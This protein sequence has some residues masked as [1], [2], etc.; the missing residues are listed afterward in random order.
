MRTREQRRRLEQ[1]R[2]GEI[3]IVICEKQDLA[4]GHSAFTIDTTSLAID[5]GKGKCILVLPARLISFL[6]L[7]LLT[8]PSPPP[9]CLHGL[10]SRCLPTVQE[11]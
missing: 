6:R 10:E 11:T 8:S 9:L 4:T 2:L 3:A 7:L 1:M 5:K